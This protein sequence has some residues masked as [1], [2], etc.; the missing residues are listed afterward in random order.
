MAMILAIFL[1]F[2]Y[3]GI[4]RHNILWFEFNSVDDVTVYSIGFIAFIIIEINNFK[5]FSNP[6]NDI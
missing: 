6:K 4:W 5:V 2:L 1:E 3:L